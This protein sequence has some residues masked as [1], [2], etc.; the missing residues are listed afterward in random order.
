[1]KSFW[2]VFVFV[3]V[4]CCVVVPYRHYEGFSYSPSG[5]DVNVVVFGSGRFRLNYVENVFLVADGFSY[6]LNCG[7]ESMFPVFGCD[8][9][10]L[11]YHPSSRLEVRVG[12][13]LG[14]R[15]PDNDDF[16][17][18]HRVVGL[19][20]GRFVMK[21]DNNI[22]NDSYMPFF[23]DVEYKVVGILYQ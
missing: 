1:M 7:S 23:G 10:L 5:L 17:I 11:A 14:Y 13:I 18:V 19:S 22:V 4:C 20:G 2:F 16:F 3:L 9:V 12:D 8:D 15:E 21:G 6:W